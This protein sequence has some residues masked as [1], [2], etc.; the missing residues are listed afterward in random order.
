[1]TLW[2]CRGLCCAPAPVNLLPAGIGPAGLTAEVAMTFLKNLFSSRR[3]FALTV[4][5]TICLSV[6]LVLFAPQQA[7]VVHYKLTLVLLAGLVL[8]LLD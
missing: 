8:Y 6:L 5:A 2:P 3:W 4:L 7:P 1:M